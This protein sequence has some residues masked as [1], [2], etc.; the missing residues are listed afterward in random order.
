MHVPHP[1][2]WRVPCVQQLQDGYSDCNHF[3]TVDQHASC[4]NL[5]NWHDASLFIREMWFT[6]CSCTVNGVRALNTISDYVLVQRNA[7]SVHF[8]LSPKLSR[9]GY[10]MHDSCSSHDP[11]PAPFDLEKSQSPLSSI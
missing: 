4:G 11:R 10:I 2:L 9:D 8:S 1:S 7:K 3:S 6:D 5:T